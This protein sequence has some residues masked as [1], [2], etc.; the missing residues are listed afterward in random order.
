M[1]IH[2]SKTITYSVDKNKLQALVYLVHGI[3]FVCF[4]FGFKIL[5][6]MENILFFGNTDKI[7]G[8]CSF[9]GHVYW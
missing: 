2:I 9:L 1:V 3:D 8:F 6:Y 5:T 4:Q 7:N